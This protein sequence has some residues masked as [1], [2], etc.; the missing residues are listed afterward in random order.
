G[1]GRQRLPG[2]LHRGPAL[3]G[4]EL[5]LLRQPLRGAGRGAHPGRRG[6]RAARP[7][8]SARAAAGQA[9]A[10]SLRASADLRRAA[11][12]RWMIPWVTARSIAR[13][14]SC[15]AVADS[16]LLPAGASRAPL[17]LERTAL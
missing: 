17:M 13:M 8:R 1:G 2:V 6:R 4:P 7:R 3:P 15:T 12:L 10:L 16:A 5:H 14:A 11:V 9:G